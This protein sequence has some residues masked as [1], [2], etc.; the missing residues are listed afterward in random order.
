MNRHHERFDV[1]YSQ[2]LEMGSQSRYVNRVL[3]SSLLGVHT[4][5]NPKHALVLKISAFNA[6]QKSA[7]VIASGLPWQL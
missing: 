2:D 1:N 4:I 7:N 6:L 5:E 3:M